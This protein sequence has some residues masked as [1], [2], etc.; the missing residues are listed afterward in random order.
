MYGF[1]LVACDEPPLEAPGRSRP[2]AAAAKLQHIEKL[3]LATNKVARAC[4]GW[5]CYAL[6]LETV[7]CRFICRAQTA[8][9]TRRTSCFESETRDNLLK[10]RLLSDCIRS[11]T[12]K[13]E[14][15]ELIKSAL[16]TSLV[17]RVAALRGLP[18]SSNML[19]YATSTTAIE[20]PRYTQPPSLAGSLTTPHLI[21]QTFLNKPNRLKSNRL[22]STV[23]GVLMEENLQRA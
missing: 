7:T 15:I 21:V 14:A 13:A 6:Q 4:L 16:P 2:A 17:W 11:E 22:N 5:L 12:F 1:A 23:C 8:P 9:P 19:N 3:A 10:T 20:Q 18:R